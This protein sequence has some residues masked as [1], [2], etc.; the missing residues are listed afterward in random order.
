M[1]NKDSNVPID[2]TTSNR[3]LRHNVLSKKMA[4]LASEAS[5]S[6]AKYMYLLDISKSIEE[7]RF[8]MT[9]EEEKETQAQCK[10]K[11]PAQ[12]GNTPHPDGFGDYLQNPDIVSSKGRPLS[13]K[14]RMSYFEELMTQNEITCGHCGSH[15]HN[16]AGCMFLHLPASMFQNQKK[17]KKQTPKKTTAPKRQAGNSS[18]H[19]PFQ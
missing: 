11:Q 9:L 3:H 13:D 4:S 17:K 1:R 10:G 18:Y 6:N 2:L 7:K 16:I 8:E 14:R 19:N 12:K 15:E 5:Y